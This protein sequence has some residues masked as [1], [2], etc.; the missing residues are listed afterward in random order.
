MLRLVER[1]EERCAQVL[2]GLLVLLCICKGSQKTVRPPLQ[3]IPV[4]IPFH[5]VAVDI[6]QLPL[7]LKGNRYV[8]VLF[9]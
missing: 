4:G 9:D 7:T 8:A 5:R 3:P 1:N 2:Q 6:L